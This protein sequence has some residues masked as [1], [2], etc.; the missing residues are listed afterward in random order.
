MLWSCSGKP[1]AS[2]TRMVFW[3]APDVKFPHA[4]AQFICRSHSSLSTSAPPNPICTRP[5]HSLVSWTHTALHAISV[6]YNLPAHS[7]K[8]GV[9][10]SV[11]SRKHTPAPAHI[12]KHSIK[13]VVETCASSPAAPTRVERLCKFQVSF[14]VVPLL[15]TQCSN[16]LNRSSHRRR[17]TPMHAPLPLAPNQPDGTAKLVHAVWQLTIVPAM[18]LERTTSVGKHTSLAVLP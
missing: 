16:R 18:S 10:I 17:P 2:Y 3:R 1:C 14:Q 9:A 12:P 4:A 6:C 5:K 13:S 8:R 15:L 11:S 7:S